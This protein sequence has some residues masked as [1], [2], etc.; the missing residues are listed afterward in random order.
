MSELKIGNFKIESQAHYNALLESEITSTKELKLLDKN[1]DKII[2]EDELNSLLETD[3]EEINNTENSTTSNSNSSSHM[4][5]EEYESLLADLKKALSDLENRR[6]EIISDVGIGSDIETLDG[7]LSSL[8][9]IMSNISSARNDIMNLMDKKASSDEY[10]KKLAKY[11]KTAGTSTS[12]STSKIAKSGNKNGINR[13]SK[14][15]FDFEENM[16]DS[17]ISQLPMFVDV[18]NNNKDKYE[19]V[20][21]AT[22]VPAELIAAIHWRESGCNFSTY[23]HNGDPLGQP[24]TH[25]PYGKMFY[26]WEDAAIDAINSQT[27]EVDANNIDTWYEY[28]ER[29]NGL[30]YRNRGVTSPYVW[31]G[32]TNY[33]GGKYVADGVYDSS[34]YDQQ[35]GVA[36]MLKAIVK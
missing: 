3:N 23:L 31:A 26:N 2:S 21:K 7:N 19:K 36:L 15:S 20:A 25:V 14:I 28:A 22:G 27:Y 13:T 6:D 34:A 5:D 16:S 1:K 9:E 8:S 10:V 12:S 30:G 35:L 18:W 29:Y 24:T 32:T 17:Q 4:S 33:H 11:Q